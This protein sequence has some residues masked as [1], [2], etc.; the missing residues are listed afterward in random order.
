M[1]ALLQDANRGPL[2]GWR[3]NGAGGTNITPAAG[4]W[5]EAS[6]GIVL[7]MMT[8]NQTRVVPGYPASEY[9]ENVGVQPD[10]EYDYMTKENLTR[11][12]RPFVDAFTAA[13]LEEIR[14]KQ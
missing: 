6:A 5:S 8:R 1:P 2:F 13:I 4:A 10:I 11:A 7:G 3:T 14:S 9:I 12:G